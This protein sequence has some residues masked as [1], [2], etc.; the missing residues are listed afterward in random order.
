[1]NRSTAWRTH[2]CGD[3]RAEDVGL[4]VRLCGWVSSR[5]DHG[6]VYFVDLRDRYGITQIFVDETVSEN[7]GE[8]MSS[9][10]QE[11]VLGITGIVQMRIDGQR[12]PDRATGDVEVLLTSIEV[13]SPADTLPFEILDEID[14]PEDIRLRYRYLDMRRQPLQSALRMRSKANQVIRNVLCE[15]EFVEVETPMLTRSTPEGARD[16]LVPSR[17]KEDSWFALPQSPQIFKQLCMV[18]G[19]D[20]YFQIAR[21]MRDEDLRA[22]RQPEF[23]QLDLEMSFVDEEDVYALV[24]DVI[25]RLY[26]EIKGLQLPKP[27][28]RIP[29]S[30]AIQR[31]ATDKPDLRNPLF[32]VDLID[33]AGDLGFSVFDNVLSNSGY[34]RAIKVPGGASLSRKQID[35]IENLAKESGVGG[36]AWFKV[37]KD[38]V[39]GPLSRFLKSSS[40]SH[41]LELCDADVG[42][43]VF[44]IADTPRRALVALDV[45]RRES[46][47]AM[48]L[49]HEDIDR[50]V[51]VTEFPLFEK[52][53]QGEFHP[54][55][56]PFTC[57][58]LEDLPAL[59]KGQKGDIRSR[60]YD[61]VLNGVEL[62]SGSVRIHDSELQKEI[63]SAI[64]LP[65]KVAAERFQ[66]L[67]RA[68][69]FGAPPHAGFAVGLDRLYNLMFGTH[70]IRDVIAFPKTATTAC[71]L[72][73]APSK[74]DAE[75]L[76]EL[77]IIQKHEK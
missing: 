22:D 20:R 69:R 17:V 60:A 53:D 73:E 29:Y 59:K 66:F 67:L 55:H 34:V 21:C 54:A 44:T 72:T 70:S 47:L 68:F 40:A 24:E 3:L 46:A 43:L 61:L 45:V 77:G 71:P 4:E 65:E 41:F 36:A 42:D 30:H 51:W 74:V 57:P 5:R 76:L 38:G 75:Q 15:H 52:N 14:V 18:G 13:L 8:Q 11:D 2:S 27:F 10:H 23:T 32:V 31:Y 37:S 56:H 12:N 9:L 39:T 35:I 7:L 1:M 63:F 33:C 6:G 50:I 49:I 48:N 19:L 16:Y 62:G 25:G 26:F 64:G 58:V 28:E